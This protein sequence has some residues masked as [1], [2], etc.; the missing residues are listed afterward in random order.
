MRGWESQLRYFSRSYRCI[1]FNA[2]GY[3][4]SDIPQNADSY[5]WELAVDDI[6]A[7][8]RGLDMAAARIAFT[9]AGKRDC[10]SRRGLRLSSLPPRRLVAGN[11]GSRAG[12]QRARNDSDG[13]ADGARSGPHPAQVQRSEGLAR[14]RYPAAPVL[15]AGDVEYDGA[16]SGVAAIG[17]RSS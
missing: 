11:L 3:P 13:R 15:A 1:A 16:L 14:I 10:R 7:V 9:E 2:R 12:L 17:A 4:R 5:G 6:A 8:M